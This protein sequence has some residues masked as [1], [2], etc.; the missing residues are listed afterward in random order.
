MAKTTFGWCSL[1]LLLLLT[2]SVFAPAQRKPDLTAAAQPQPVVRPA[3][4]RPIVAAAVR[5]REHHFLDRRN[6]FL[7]AA[8]IAGRAADVLTTWR[9]RDRGYREVVLSNSFVDNRPA[10]AAYSFGMAGANIAAAYGLHRLGWHK[11]E[12]ALSLVHISYMG[13]LA[14]HNYTLVQPP[15]TATPLR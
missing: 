10:F 8:V 2:T 1:V 6:S 5:P 4:V 15:T 7:F 13:A 9:F 12:R 11:A 14:I 3:E